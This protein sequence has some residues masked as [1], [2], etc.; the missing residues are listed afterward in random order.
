MYIMPKIRSALSVFCIALL[1]MTLTLPVSA[2]KKSQHISV[3]QL[4]N[5]VGIKS[6]GTSINVYAVCKQVVYSASEASLYSADKEN[7]ACIETNE[8]VLRKENNDGTISQTN[9]CFYDETGKDAKLL[10]P[11]E[12]SATSTMSTSQFTG[13]PIRIDAS[14]PIYGDT[15]Y[16]YV[17]TYG[18]TYDYVN[19]NAFYT[20]V[21]PDSIF[22]RASSYAST[23]HDIDYLEVD[24]SLYGTVFTETT[25][26]DFLQGDPVGSYVYIDGVSNPNS[27]RT[28]TFSCASDYQ[29][30]WGDD[31]IGVWNDHPMNN[32]IVDYE[33]QFDD[34]IVVGYYSTIF[35]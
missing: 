28:Y 4:M 21:R 31:W 19:Y 8:I 35:G 20:L 22:I 33:V 12:V 23:T 2:E 13:N 27:G 32:F 25:S 1:L 11:V 24:I 10:I 18:A 16:S 7:A 30:E 14:D 9:V 29:S 5:E 6:G 34:G 17:V 15:S 3:A 26:G